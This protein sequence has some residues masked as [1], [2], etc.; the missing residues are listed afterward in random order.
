MSFILWRVSIQMS[1]VESELLSRWH[2]R[3]KMLPRKPMLLFS[4]YL[5]VS[6]PRCLQSKVQILHLVSIMSSN[7]IVLH[8]GS[9]RTVN[10]TYLKAP[11]CGMAWRKVMF[12]LK[13]NVTTLKSWFAFRN[14]RTHTHTHTHP[15][16]QTHTHK[17]PPTHAHT[18][19]QTNTHT[20]KHTHT[21]THTHT[22]PHNT[23]HT[24]THTAIC[25]KHLT[26][27]PLVVL[28]S[29]TSFS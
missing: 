14:G 6:Y 1:E 26:F 16:T 5:K 17:H 21:N 19:T 4:S 18:H 24:H 22:H 12:V 20:H 8:D 15:H 29:A 27:S 28:R 9:C 13:F 11:R 3:I 25:L 23:Y 2:P 7:F 10:C